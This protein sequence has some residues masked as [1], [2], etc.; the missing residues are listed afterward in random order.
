MSVI[1]AMNEQLAAEE[2]TRAIRTLLERAGIYRNAAACS[3]LVAGSLS[4]LI[5]VGIYLNNETR[6][7]MGR[8]IRARDFA[9]LWIG[10]FILSVMATLV[11]L[12][13]EARRTGRPLFSSEFKLVRNQI[14]PFLL[15]PAAYTGWFFTTGFLGAQELNLVVVWM[16]FY[17][18]TLLSTSLF[19]PRS[20]TLLGWIFVLTSLAVPV[21]TNVIEGYISIDVPNVLMGATFGLYHLIY[22]AFNWS[23]K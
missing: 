6:F 13:R 23:R 15:I 4:M 18:L 19:A 2:R 9:A 17:G 7:N 1:S 16:A 11:F 5:S 21:I 14:A 20:I 8:S 3:A 22:A 10:V 12:A